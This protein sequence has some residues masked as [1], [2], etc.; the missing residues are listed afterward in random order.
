MPC[1]ITCAKSHSRADQ[2]RFEMDKGQDRAHGK[3]LVPS[4]ASIDLQKYVPAKM[5]KFERSTV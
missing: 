2:I 4:C 3:V 1:G 5:A